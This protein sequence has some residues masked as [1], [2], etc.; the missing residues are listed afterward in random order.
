MKAISAIGT[1]GLLIGSH[2]VAADNSGARIV[3]ITGV[4]HGKTR[5]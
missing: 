2:C 5:K 1:R 4:K 3:K